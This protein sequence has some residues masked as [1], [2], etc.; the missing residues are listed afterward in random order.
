[1]SARSADRPERPATTF[2]EARWRF[3]ELLRQDSDAVAPESRSRLISPGHRTQ[4]A[5][6]FFHG[7]TNSP[8]QFLS[9][10]ERFTARGYAI[11]VPR[12]AYHGYLDRMTTD[13]AHLR[14]SDLVDGA[15]AALDLAGGLADEITVSGISMGGVLAI[16]AAQYRPVAVVAPIAPAI[17]VPVLPY[18]LTGTVFGALGRLPNRFVWW[19]PRY[20]QNLPGPPYAYPRFS[21]H[22]LVETQRLALDLVDAARDAPP[23][24]HKVWMISNAADLAVSNAAS[25]LLVKH[26]SEAGA[27]NVRTFQFPR[28]LKLFHDL[29]DPLQPNSQSDLVH[30]ILE[31]IIVDDQ[32]P[33]VASLSRSAG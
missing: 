7:L 21:T 16:W 4:R 13:H 32:L 9:L 24:A 6:V 10:S 33:N 20:K 3:E 15:A 2:D 22:A 17:G 30:P 28:H 1:M 12:I 27:T 26:W 11:F 8:Q 5:I 29:V 19:D 31:T 18:A 23:R 25:A 14:A